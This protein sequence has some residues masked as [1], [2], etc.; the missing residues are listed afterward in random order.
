MT[1]RILL[2]S[3]VRKAPCCSRNK[4]NHSSTRLRR[5]THH[6]GAA[7]QLFV[8]RP[9]AFLRI[10]RRRRRRRRICRLRLARVRPPAKIGVPNWRSLRVHANTVS[11][12]R[13]GNNSGALKGGSSGE[14]FS[15]LRFVLPLR[16]SHPSSLSSS[17]SFLLRCLRF[18]LRS[19]SSSLLLL[20]LLLLACFLDFLGLRD[21]TGMSLSSELSFSC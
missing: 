18:G 2:A 8:A 3:T 9:A 11:G 13:S 17:S 16:P 10:C 5:R 19:S 1:E 6:H 15:H 4:K 14:R 7:A 12:S 21:D 20:L